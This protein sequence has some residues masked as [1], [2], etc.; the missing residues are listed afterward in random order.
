M[1]V[2]IA[3]FFDTDE[4]PWNYM[5]AIGL[6]YA[7]PPIAIFYGLRRYIAAGLTLGAIKG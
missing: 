2:G 4:A 6:V 1:A 5:M 3:Q 7:V